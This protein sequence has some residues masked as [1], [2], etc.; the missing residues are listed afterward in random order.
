[1]KVS[2]CRREITPKGEFFPCYLMG[3]AIRTAPATGILDPLWATA[4]LLEAEGVKL[5]WITVELIGL[6]RDYTE[7]LQEIIE[8][9]YHISK[10]NIS[11]CFI[12][13]HS[14]PEY[15]EVSLLGGPGAIP[16]Y[17]DFVAGEILTAVEECFSGEQKDVR[18]YERTLQITG[19]YGNRNGKEKPC[20]KSFTTL[21]FKKGDQVVAGAGCFACHS[22][23]LGPDNLKVSSDLAGFAARVLER[24][25]G[26]Y[27][28]MMIGAA[29]DVSNRLY[30]QGNDLQELNRVG[31]EM[32]AQ[33][34][35]APE[36][37]LTLQAPIVRTFR[38]QETYYPD[39]NKKEAQYREIMEKIENARS[40]DEKKVYSSALAIARNGLA[41]EP[42]C[43]DLICRYIDMGE[44]KIMT[45]PAELFSCFGIRLKAAMGASCSICWCYNNY[46]VGYLGNQEDYG[47]S[48]ET[49]SSDIPAG[50]T[51]RIVEQ[52]IA[53]I[54]NGR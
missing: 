30:R 44:L 8:E 14:A 47:A 13:T 39:K 46:N 22:T 26:V 37:E 41:C 4:L 31:N 7:K 18:L 17:M 16:G 9:K 2:T 25:W 24:E 15:Q 29:G 20:D 54:Q 38:F 49:A 21:A 36:R 12:H 40:F 19:C 51:E 45:I 48:F 5:L 28:V 3:H 52:M 6:E 35:A 42:F 34:L 32:M 11:I 1:M 10:E 50:T 53:F 43:L 27:P 23:V 33:V